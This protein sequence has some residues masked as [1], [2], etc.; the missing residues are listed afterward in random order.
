M[1]NIFSEYL[2]DY[3]DK[4]PSHDHDDLDME[5]LVTYVDASNRIVFPEKVQ[6]DKAFC[7]ETI[8]T[9][10]KCH[11]MEEGK[12]CGQGKLCQ[13]CPIRAIIRESFASGQPVIKKIVDKTLTYDD[14]RNQRYFQ[15]TTNFLGD[16]KDRLLI[17]FD[18]VTKRYKRDKLVVIENHLTE[19]EAVESYDD[20]AMYLV[21]NLKQMLSS[22]TAI[23]SIMNP[24]LGFTK[25]LYESS[26]SGF[27]LLDKQCNDI[28]DRKTWLKC[29]TKGQVIIQNQYMDHSDSTSS[30]LD[31]HRLI[32]API[33]DN[34]QAIGMLMVMNKSQ[35]YTEL[36]G[37][38][39]ED[40]VKKFIKTIHHKQLMKKAE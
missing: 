16:K 37:A 8:G 15:I 6:I 17:V 27:K 21:E 35:A 36:D 28:V 31:I 14:V 4:E 38:L 9:A 40:I 22:E 5:M 24:A 23:I 3:W 13:T 12:A 30:D 11:D 18:D 1:L 10:I 19:V 20:M 7:N 34:H 32:I 26:S 39:L 33:I 2:E 25:H 29:L